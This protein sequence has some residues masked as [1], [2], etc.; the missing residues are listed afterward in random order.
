MKSLIL[1]ITTAVLMVGFG[2]PEDALECLD[3]FVRVLSV[4]MDK[5]LS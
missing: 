1:I 5:P 4:M 3:Y 2:R